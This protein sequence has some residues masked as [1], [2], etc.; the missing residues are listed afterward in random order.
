MTTAHFTVDVGRREF[1]LDGWRWLGFAV[2]ALRWNAGSVVASVAVRLCGRG[3]V[4]PM[5]EAVA[6]L[7]W[8]ILPDVED[9]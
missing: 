1:R 9:P 4:W 8:R 2:V 7:L 5:P 6:P 3:R